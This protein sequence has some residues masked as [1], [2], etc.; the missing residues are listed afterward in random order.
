MKNITSRTGAHVWKRKAEMPT[1]WRHWRE[2]EFYSIVLKADCLW[3]VRYGITDPLESRTFF[4][5]SDHV[6]SYIEEL[7]E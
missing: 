2:N 7:T 4:S 1:Y 3:S 5:L 6:G